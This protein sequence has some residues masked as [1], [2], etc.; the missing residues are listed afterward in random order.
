M[1][2]V[3]ICFSLTL[4]DKVAFRAAVHPSFGLEE[5]NP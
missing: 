1:A 5:F 2:L 3:Y 4:T